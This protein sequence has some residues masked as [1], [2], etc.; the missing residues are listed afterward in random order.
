MKI[1]RILVVSIL[2]SIMVPF[3]ALAVTEYPWKG[4]AKDV[5][6]AGGLG[7]ITVTQSLVLPGTKEC[8][9]MIFQSGDERWGY[10]AGEEDPEEFKW[11]ITLYEEEDFTARIQL[12]F[13]TYETYYLGINP[14]PD[15]YA[16]N[17]PKNTSISW[18]VLNDYMLSESGK[19]RP[20]NISAS[21]RISKES[22]EGILSNNLIMIYNE[23][24]EVSY[25]KDISYIFN[26]KKDS[27]TPKE[28]LSVSKES[29]ETLTEP[30]AHPH[31]TEPFQSIEPS[32]KEKVSSI[33]TVIPFVILLIFM[34]IAIRKRKHK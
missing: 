8:N 13:S 3:V 24:N 5:E 6:R 14:I 10:M 21:C 32:R 1:L 22:P 33:W 26:E 23:N 15:K 27:T 7:W 19:A 20:E 4:S 29:I 31:Q 16:Q 25:T 12:P 28:E 17:I 9:V 34:F 18:F 11:I 2:I 30:E